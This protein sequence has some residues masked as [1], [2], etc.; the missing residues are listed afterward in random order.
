MKLRL[1]VAVSLLLCGAFIMVSAKARPA[2]KMFRDSVV[3]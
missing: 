1:S 3:D 2:G